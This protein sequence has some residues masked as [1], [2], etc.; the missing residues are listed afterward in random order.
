MLGRAELF[1]EVCC[2]VLGRAALD[3]EVVPYC[4]MKGCIGW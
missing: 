3:G 1:D 4:V 2:I